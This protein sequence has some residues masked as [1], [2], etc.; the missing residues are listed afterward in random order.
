M[1][2]FIA[3]HSQWLASNGGAPPGDVFG[4]KTSLYVGPQWT[5]VL[6]MVQMPTA[7]ESH[8]RRDM[9]NN[10]N[11]K[12]KLH[13]TKW[14][15]LWSQKCLHKSNSSPH[16]NTHTHTQEI[17]PSHL[18]RKRKSP[19]IFVYSLPL[20]YWYDWHG[21]QKTFTALCSGIRVIKGL[22]CF[23]K[24]FLDFHKSQNFL[25]VEQANL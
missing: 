3:N 4:G 25:F 11:Y 14:R 7:L 19:A 10:N 20:C 23:F 6:H 22:L 13:G 8:T 2:Q 12:T 1:R 5:V 17:L 16:T 15:E 18:R 9:H 21:R 24:V